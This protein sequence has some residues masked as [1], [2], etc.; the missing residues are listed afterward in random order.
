MGR[1]A[2]QPCAEDR[3]YLCR[4]HPYREIFMRLIEI[5][6][7]SKKQDLTPL[8]TTLYGENRISGDAMKD[9]V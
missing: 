2:R 4:F 3:R 1:G 6:E 7:T 8:L 5:F 9:L